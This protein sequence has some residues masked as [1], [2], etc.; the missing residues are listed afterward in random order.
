MSPAAH[1]LVLD[2]IESMFRQLSTGP[3]A[4]ALDGGALGGVL[5]AESMPLDEMRNLLLNPPHPDAATTI[6]RE[7]VERTRLPTDQDLWTVVAVGAMT[8]GL[9]GMCRRA[10]VGPSD[11]Q[12]L[13]AELVAQFLSCLAV[14]RP[15][16]P[17]LVGQLYWSA[18]RAVGR[19]RQGVIEAER[20][21]IAGDIDPRLVAGA[22][23]VGH[24]DVALARLCTR[25]VINA[26][27]ADLIGR[28]R[29]EGESLSVAA[30]RLG[31]TYAACRKRR[32]RAE[33]RIVEHY[34]RTGVLLPERA[35][36][37]MRGGL[38]FTVSGT[39]SDTP[40]RPVAA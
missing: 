2:R 14:V 25:G 23:L 38:D 16:N 30:A 9:R 27:D 36:Q 3:R 1:H 8:P 35:R 22:G 37:L 17:R 13:Q 18:Q 7:L 15:E 21:L 34:V 4:L 11:H 20:L 12:D 5:P 31:I 19:F 26:Q 32:R 33:N 24:P 40:C 29:L 10:G 6:W 39:G 28:T